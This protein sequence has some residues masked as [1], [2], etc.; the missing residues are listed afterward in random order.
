M[1]SANFQ[2]KSTAV[3][4]KWPTYGEIR[5]QLNRKTKLLRVLCL[6]IDGADHKKKGTSTFRF[7][8]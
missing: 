2:G 8:L 3:R 5:V 7:Y 4:I 6:N 1:T